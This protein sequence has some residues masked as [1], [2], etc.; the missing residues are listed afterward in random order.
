MLELR[1]F[2]IDGKTPEKIGFFN[3]EYC[4]I[5]GE[6]VQIHGK[7]YQVQQKEVVLNKT[8]NYIMFG[9]V[10]LEIESEKKCPKP[11]KKTPE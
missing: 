1:F 7:K 6:V 3:G 5:L 11:K 4:P 2:C 10:S 9:V 8:D